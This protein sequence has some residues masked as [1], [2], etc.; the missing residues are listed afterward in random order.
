MTQHG[1]NDP[2]GEK[3]PPGGTREVRLR[4]VIDPT[5]AE[6]L[7]SNMAS[8][9]S[10]PA[11]FFIDFGR[12]VPGRADFKV[13]ARIIMTPVHAKQLALALAEH[14]RQYERAHGEIGALPP[15]DPARKLGLH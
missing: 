13:L 4:S 15:D 3:G 10:G 14:V 7:Y 6:G 8:I 11:E 1:S 9:M 5:V 12:V 2:P